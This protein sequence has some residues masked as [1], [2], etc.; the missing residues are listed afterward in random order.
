LP[1]ILALEHAERQQWVSQVAKI[2]SRLN[3]AARR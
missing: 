2:N 1:D 3:E